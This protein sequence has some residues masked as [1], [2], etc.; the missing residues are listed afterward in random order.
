MFLL[1]L[2][3]YS[4]EYFHGKPDVPYWGE[5]SGASLDVTL[6]YLLAAMALIFIFAINMFK[7]QYAFLGYVIIVLTMVSAVILLKSL[8]VYELDGIW[9]KTYQREIVPFWGVYKFYATL[10][11]VS[12]PMQILLHDVLPFF[13]RFFFCTLAMSLGINLLSKNNKSLS[14]YIISFII[15]ILS[16]AK[17]WFN[18]YAAGGDTGL[19]IVC[20]IA[21]FFGSLLAKSIF[22]NAKS[23]IFKKRK[24]VF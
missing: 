20:G 12:N 9:L 6:V 14:P 5:G 13:G 21:V 23:L 11:D 24:E 19:F 2:S 7:K 3:A 16:L 22:K 10:Y 15:C 8:F 4:A 17:P 18:G 1:N